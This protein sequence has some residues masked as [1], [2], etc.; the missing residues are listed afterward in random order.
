M[1]NKE[2][3]II[4]LNSI[5]SIFSIGLL[6]GSF[7][8]KNVQTRKYLIII[9][10]LILLVLKVLDIFI[11]KQTRKASIIILIAIIILLIYFAAF[12]Y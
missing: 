10:L 12:A 7:F 11:I 6:I 9:A 3:K 8:L 5:F 4:V 1:T 2:L